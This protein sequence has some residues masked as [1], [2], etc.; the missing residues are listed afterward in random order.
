M[1]KRVFFGRRCVLYGGFSTS[2]NQTLGDTWTW[3]G[4]A[5]SQRQPGI[6][7]TVRSSHAMAYDRQRARVVLFGGWQNV[8]NNYY[9][10][11]TWEWDGTT[12][13]L[14]TTTGPVPRFGQGAPP[15]KLR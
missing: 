2:G 9:L 11:D 14:R 13:L 4:V 10:G 8:Y 12:W 5:W 7:P 3:N 15:S 6:S 1:R